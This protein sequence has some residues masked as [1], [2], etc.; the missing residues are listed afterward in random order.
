MHESSIIHNLQNVKL[1][2]GHIK[3]AQLGTMIWRGRSIV[4][5]ELWSRK[6]AKNSCVFTTETKRN[7][8]SSLLGFVL[9]AV[10][11]RMYTKEENL[12]KWSIQ[13]NMGIPWVKKWN[14]REQ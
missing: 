3:K 9:I 4:Y 1:R 10:A 12:S 7:L 14:R 11:N 6:P 8:K 2:W 5:H 13:R